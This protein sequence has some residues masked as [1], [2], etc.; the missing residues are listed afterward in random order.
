MGATEKFFCPH[1]GA[2]YAGDVRARHRSRQFAQMRGLPRKHAMAR[3]APGATALSVDPATRGIVRF[4]SRQ[5]LVVAT[6][7]RSIR[8]PAR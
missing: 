7:A 6:A 4:L 5:A 2:L 1:C 8:D 3:R